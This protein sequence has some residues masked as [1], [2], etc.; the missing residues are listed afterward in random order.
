MNTRK[1]DVVVL[2]LQIVA[3]CFFI[4]SSNLQAQV[5][6]LYPVP[7][8]AQVAF[9][10]VRERLYLGEPGP[11]VVRALNLADGSEIYA[12]NLTLSPGVMVMS[13]DGN[14][15]YVGET[16]TNS[17]AL[18]PAKIAEIDL[19]SG[20]LM[21]EVDWGYAPKG[22]VATDSG[23]LAITSPATYNF[24]VRLFDIHTGTNSSY[25]PCTVPDIT[26]DSDQKSVF[27]YGIGNV[28]APV[29]RAYIDPAQVAFTTLRATTDSG[30]VSPPVASP[31][32]ALLISETSAY[33]GSTNAALDMT[34]LKTLDSRPGGTSDAKFK[35]T[36]G[37][38]FVLASMYGLSF[39]RRDTLQS[40]SELPVGYAV[41]VAYVGD[42]VYAVLLDPVTGERQLIRVPDPSIGIE[43][44]QPPA[45]EFT[46][47][48]T[49]PTTRQIITLDASASRDDIDS[50]AQLLYRWDFDGD[51]VFD[52]ELSTNETVS[53]RLRAPGPHIITLEAQDRFGATQSVQHT[54]DVTLE[55]Y[56]GV[57]GGTNTPWQLPFAAE[58][59]AFDPIRPF[60]YASDLLG[61][62]LVALNLT[63]GLIEHQWA[64][65][66][67]PVAITVSPDASR[68]Y[69][70][71]SGNEPW[72][73][74]SVGRGWVAEIDLGD[75]VLTHEFP[76]SLQVYSLVATDPGWVIIHGENPQR[77]I[78][79]YRGQTGERTAG[80]ALQ[81][82]CN[83]AL[84]PSQA[85]IYA[86]N[87]ELSPPSLSRFTLDNIAGTLGDYRNKAIANNGSVFPLP[88]GTALVTAAGT[89]LDTN[90]LLLQSLTIGP[91][92][93]VPLPERGLMAFFV[94]GEARYLRTNTWDQF[95]SQPASWDLTYAGR[96]DNQLF[97]A[98]ISGT[99]TF[100]LPRLVPAVTP[101]QDLPP[102]VSWVA[103][104]NT[105]VVQ[106]GGSLS[107][108]AQA[109]DLDGAVQNIS[110][111]TNGALMFNGSYLSY[112]Q[113]PAGTYAVTAVAADNL[114]VT[115]TSPVLTVII[116]RPPTVSLQD[117]AAGGPLLSP[118]S[119][120]LHADA[121]D[122]DGQIARVDFHYYTDPTHPLH[123]GS[124]FSAP[125]DLPVHD[126]IGS[127]G[128]LHVVAVDN[129]GATGD[130]I[131]PLRILG[132]L[133]DD[134]YRPFVAPPGPFTA[135]ANN[136]AATRQSNEPILGRYPAPATLWWNWTAPSNCVVVVDTFGSAIDTSLAVVTGTNITALPR[137]TDNDDDLGNA[138]ASRVKFAAVSGTTYDLVVGSS[139]PSETGDIVLNLRTVALPP[140]LSG[141]PPTNDFRT[142]AIVLEGTNVTAFG[143]NV[144]ATVDPS[145]P[146]FGLVLHKSVWWTWT[147]PTNGHVTLDTA[148]SDFDTLLGVYVGLSAL[149]T[150]DDVADALT[151]KVSFDAISGRAYDF[152]VDGFAGAS[153][154]IQLNLALSTQP[155]LIPPGNDMFNDAYSING[156]LVITN[157]Y[158]DGA[159]IEPGEPRHGGINTSKSVWWKW[160]AVESGPV[161]IKARGRQINLSSDFALVIAVYT[162]TD[163]GN[164]LPVMAGFPVQQ[165]AN[166]Q[167]T[168]ARFQAEAGQT[169]YFATASAYGSAGNIDLVLNARLRPAF[170]LLEA[171]EL[172][173]GGQVR[174]TILS[175]F[176]RDVELQGSPDL[177]QWTS[178]STN[179]VTDRLELTV[180]QGPSGATA[181]FYRL[182]AP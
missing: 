62:R 113:P 155:R 31:D 121:N 120:T 82:P 9:D 11:Q 139:M 143:S 76:I 173:A 40:F 100:I 65:Y 133:G 72:F 101:D 59:A 53:I 105:T 125:Y 77:R 79:V 157:G 23:L 172:Q 123:L 25:W 147:A 130:Q 110:L 64:L 28:F 55:A 6:N 48:P 96:F 178:L 27:G 122:P 114:G 87:T 115:N 106:E 169:Y 179:H 135:H 45:P 107:L 3:G 42:W 92:A 4:L 134:F 84:H 103:P 91:R 164:L 102:L 67:D 141:S 24:Q 168:I 89:L 69:L 60:L 175:S 18:P 158:N 136:S 98:A 41:G 5:E 154:N 95:L 80:L 156:D 109:Q 54:I 148:G 163:V 167:A 170:L 111:Y 88:D 131:L 180:P 21:Q 37:A 36:N 74:N 140:D 116:N 127:G 12:L 57:A 146:T 108:Q 145:E 20:T 138:P 165:A 58:S 33:R 119:F 99:N 81:G 71:Q 78:E 61:Q 128:F 118:A 29:V 1:R 152:V 104:T 83:L 177:A 94:P 8:D 26:L 85:L 90:M 46:W 86:A 7:P 70:A 153:G 56:A 112:W 63:N 22:M 39:Y 142:N 50:P 117:P 75:F 38:T 34:F 44:N 17:G 162:G 73:I 35:G 19:T 160:T 49:N 126:L 14:R 124:V 15:L 171:P 132:L 151:S 66:T 182:L 43:T 161:F 166:A 150:S 159:T 129:Y 97:E 137:V 32:G 13:P 181:W 144:G 51:G 10:P 149:A 30:F 68:L 176:E 52:T 93:L 174:L 2:T 16:Q 47:S